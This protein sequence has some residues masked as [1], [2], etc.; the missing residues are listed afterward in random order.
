MPEIKTRTR[1]GKAKE[2]ATD[3]KANT[4]KGDKGGKR[5]QQSVKVLK[6]EEEQETDEEAG[7]GGA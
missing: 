4:G 2:K 1:P 6:G 5:F 7:P 3:E